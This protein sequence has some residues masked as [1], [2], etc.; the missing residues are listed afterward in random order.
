MADNQVHGLRKRQL[1]ASY[2]APGADEN[3]RKGAYW[4]IGTDIAD[5]KLNDSLPCKLC[6]TTKLANIQTRLAPLDRL[7]QQR[8]INWGFAVCDAA[9]R[10]Y[11]D[12]SITAPA[13]FPYPKAKV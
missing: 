13:D 2:T 5:Y 4:G 8:L 3:F 10:R 1:I 6:R 11:V 7:T 12:S 9:M